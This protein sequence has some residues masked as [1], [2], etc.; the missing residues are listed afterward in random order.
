MFGLSQIQLII[1][2]GLLAV[3]ITAGGITYI[4]SKGE[5]AG[6]S[7]VTTKV[8]QETIKT[9][10]KARVTKEQADQETIAKPYSERADGLK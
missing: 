5:R 3:V 6:S 7:S 4:Y 1:I 2:G 8:Q 10:D 9:L